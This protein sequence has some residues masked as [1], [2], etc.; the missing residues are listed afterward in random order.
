MPA[1]PRT[2]RIDQGDLA[3][4]AARSIFSKFRTLL[5]ANT[6]ALT[7][8]AKMERML[9]GEYIFD[10][11][12]MEKSARE[13]ADFA[14]QAV[15]AVNAMTGNQYVA[16]YDRF[17]A[18]DAAVE[19]ILA[20]RQEAEDDRPVR[21]VSRLHL[22]DLPKVGADG[23]ILGEL[24][25]QLG[26]RVSPVFVVTRTA[27]RDGR[28]APAA[29]RAVAAALAESTGGPGTAVTIALTSLAENGAAEHQEI[30]GVPALAEA[31]L[32]ALEEL[33]TAVQQALP[34]NS[35]QRHFRA[36]VKTMRPA[37]L[38]GRLTTS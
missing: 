13:V 9:G 29:R 24:A 22:E 35:G 2:D 14:H 33:T 1:D 31:V 27:W 37:L 8:M 7:T 11:A 3:G 6:A 17:M 4:E 23:A 30:R 28:L 5:E 25:D 26:L 38:R 18:I 10:R 15:Y 34:E 32:V 19:D 20:G 21:L 16:L 12:F 36:V